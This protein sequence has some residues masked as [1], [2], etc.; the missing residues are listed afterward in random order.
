MA[1]ARRTGGRQAI[2]ATT[3]DA[4]IVSAMTRGVRLGGAVEDVNGDGCGQ[5]VSEGCSPDA[6]EYA[7]ESA[8][9]DELPDDGC[10]GRAECLARTDLIAALGNDGDI[11]V[12]PMSVFT[13]SFQSDCYVT[14]SYSYTSNQSVKS[15]ILFLLRVILASQ[16]SQSNIR[17][18]PTISIP[19]R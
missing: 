19:V 6:A 7:E 14:G 1:A 9:A 3:M 13:L 2:T 4:M 15:I 5:A 11:S 12:V 16:L 17:T 18:P 8:L 10:R